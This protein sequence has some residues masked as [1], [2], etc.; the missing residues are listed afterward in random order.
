MP[1]KYD[2]KCENC[3]VQ[4]YK[5]Q[6]KRFCSNKCRANILKGDKHPNF[7]KKL[8]EKQ[9][10]VIRQSMLDQYTSGQRIPYQLGKP[11]YKVRGENHHA[12]KNGATGEDQTLRCRVEFKVWRRQVFEQQENKCS[13]CGETNIKLLVAHHIKYFKDYPELA[14]DPTNGVILCR[15]CHP[16]IHRPKT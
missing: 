4:V 10:E 14:Y 8:S 9:K 5:S 12:W 7:G 15:S 11:Q 3:G 13:N 2:F 16:K 1:R 6:G